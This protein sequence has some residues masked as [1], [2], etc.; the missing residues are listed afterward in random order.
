MQIDS[1]IDG[2]GVAKHHS[3]KYQAHSKNTLQNL[4]LSNHTAKLP[5]IAAK[6]GGGN[7]NIKIVSLN[8]R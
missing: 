2:S 8:F 3:T 1:P 6:Y 7:K 5:C 4:S